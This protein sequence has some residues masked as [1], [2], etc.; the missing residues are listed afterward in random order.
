MKRTL[1]LVLFFMVLISFISSCAFLQI[2]K[3]EKCIEDLK[4]VYKG[5]WVTM[6]VPCAVPDRG[7]YEFS[8]LKL[9]SNLGMITLSVG[10]KGDGAVIFTMVKEPKWLVVV[11]SKGEELTFWIHVKEEIVRVD[12]EKAKAILKPYLEGRELLM[13]PFAFNNLNGKICECGCG[14]RGCNC[15]MP[16][17]LQEI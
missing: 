16:K 15:E 6:E 14:L 11:G 2:D 17:L 9:R 4:L 10:E 13:E 7:K 12:S 1:Y 3:V 5:K 8:Y